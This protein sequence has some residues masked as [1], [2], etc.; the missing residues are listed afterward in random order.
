MNEFRRSRIGYTKI[1]KFKKSKKID[2]KAGFSKKLAFFYIKIRFPSFS[3]KL[4]EIHL[5]S[6]ILY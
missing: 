5:S 4:Q 3:N 6:I 2:K 1:E